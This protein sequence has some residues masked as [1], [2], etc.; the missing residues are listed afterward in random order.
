MV[1]SHQI[2]RFY[3]TDPI[4][5]AGRRRLNR[6]SPNTAAIADA[7]PVVTQGI[8]LRSATGGG[9]GGEPKATT[10]AL[11]DWLTVLV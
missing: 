10:P 5:P 2:I 1:S 11:C 8:R 4:P 3:W 9:E 6:S 7:I